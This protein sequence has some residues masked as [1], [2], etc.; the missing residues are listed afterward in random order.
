MLWIKIAFHG[1]QPN[2]LTPVD[3]TRII[4][5]ICTVRSVD[6]ELVSITDIYI[7]INTYIYICIYTYIY[8]YIHI[9]IYP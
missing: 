4:Y 1:K 8:M 7:Y 9:Y 6:G 2:N 5:K 3:L